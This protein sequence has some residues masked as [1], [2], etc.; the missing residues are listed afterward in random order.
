MLGKP[1][2]LVVLPLT[3]IINSKSRGAPIFG[4]L[5]MLS[6]RLGTRNTKDCQSK[7]NKQPTN[8]SM[9]HIILKGLMTPGKK[10]LLRWQ[11]KYDIVTVA[12]A[13]G[14]SMWY[15][16]YVPGRSEE[17]PFYVIQKERVGDWRERWVSEEHPTEETACPSKSTENEEGAPCLQ[18]AM[19]L[20]RKRQR[21]RHR[22]D[23]EP[24]HAAFL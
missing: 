4:I 24:V 5:M 2:S 23:S 9:P 6:L 21:P 13:Q 14:R 10:W 20:E 17:C 18:V 12:A 16:E 8:L 19:W 3:T 11:H 1:S 15:C 22:R 7:T